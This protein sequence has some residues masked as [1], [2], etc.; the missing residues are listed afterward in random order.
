MRPG[1]VP[2][3]RRETGRGCRISLSERGNLTSRSKFR[4][5]GK[6]SNPSG[7]PPSIHEQLVELLSRLGDRA[8]AEKEARH[9]HAAMLAVSRGHDIG[10]DDTGFYARQRHTKLV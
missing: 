2:D 5:N 6:K 3:L 1:D 4:W 9:I 7:A 10:R 8:I